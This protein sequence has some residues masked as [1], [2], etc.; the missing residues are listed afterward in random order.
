[1]PYA[2]RRDAKITELTRFTM[3]D[4]KTMMAEHGVT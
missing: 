1:V 3:S 4:I 2:F